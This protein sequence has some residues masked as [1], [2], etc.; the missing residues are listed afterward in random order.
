MNFICTKRQQLPRSRET[1]VEVIINLSS[2]SSFKSIK[3][4]DAV[5]L[6]TTSDTRVRVLAGHHRVV[7]L[8]KLLSTDTCVPLAKQYNLIPA[9]GR[10]CSSAVKVTGGLAESNGSTAGFYDYVTC[11]LIA[12]RLRSAPSSALVNRVYTHSLTHSRVWDY[13]IFLL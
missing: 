2:L 4:H 13:L 7:A 6:G 1:S 8:G 12:K 9:Q 10:W 5:A 3:R 11:Q